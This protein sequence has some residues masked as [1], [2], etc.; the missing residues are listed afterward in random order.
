MNNNKLNN[1]DFFI[2]R[3]Q[4]SFPT[5][6]TTSQKELNNTNTNPKTIT[7]T[8]NNINST[9]NQNSTRNH[10][11]NNFISKSNTNFTHKSPPKK[12][13]FSSL[14]IDNNSFSNFINMSKAKNK[15]YLN[16]NRNSILLADSSNDKFNKSQNS[17]TRLSTLFVEER[18]ASVN[19]KTDL[20]KKILGK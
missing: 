15:D 7:N 11:T 10:A 12:I 17:I 2:V 3:S 6:A 14:N 16:S 4:M 19:C 1:L 13:S 18:N 8:N 5:G 20:H 9:V